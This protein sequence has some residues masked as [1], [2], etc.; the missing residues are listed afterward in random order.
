MMEA[1][2]PTRH[3]GPFSALTDWSMELERTGGTSDS[4]TFHADIFR[5]GE[6]VCRIALAGHFAELDEASAAVGAR[7]HSW[8]LDYEFRPHTGDSEFQIL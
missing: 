6:F 5:R 7:F 4:K 1:M 8:L 2:Q 3:G